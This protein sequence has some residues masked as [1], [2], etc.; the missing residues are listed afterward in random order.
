MSYKNFY[1]ESWWRFGLI[2]LKQI[3]KFGEKRI[4]AKG[5][6]LLRDKLQR[7]ERHSCRS[8]RESSWGRADFSRRHRPEGHEHASRLLHSFSSSSVDP[9]VNRE[10]AP[11]FTHSCGRSLGVSFF[12]FLRKRTCLLFYSVNFK[13]P[14]KNNCN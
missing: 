13:Q 3:L 9:S 4:V 1:S 8:G 14:D 12:S 10:P 2:D 5:I 7:G 11:E 6:C